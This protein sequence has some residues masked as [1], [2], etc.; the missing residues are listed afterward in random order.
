MKF[1]SNPVV[2]LVTIVILALLLLVPAGMIQNAIH[3]R[4][5]NQRTAT[6]SV[7]ETWGGTQSIVPA[8]LVLPYIKY[9]GRTNTEGNTSQ[10]K[11]SRKLYVMPELLEVDANVTPEV[12]DKGVFQVA[13]Y[14]SDLQVTGAFTLPNLDELGI[15]PEHVLWDEAELNVGISGLKSID[16]LVDIVWGDQNVAPEAG[17]TDS[18]V[19]SSGLHAVVAATP[20]KPIP[21]QVNL[22]LK[23][24]E[25]LRIAPVGK[26]TQVTMKGPWASPAYTG[27]FSPTHRSSEDGAFKAQWDIMHL[28]KNYPQYWKES[29][30]HNVNLELVETS[31]I[32]PVDR[33]TKNHRVTKYAILIIALTFLIFFFTESMKNKYV[34]PVQYTLV[35]LALV[36]FY[37]LLL[38]FSEHMGFN[39]AYAIAT[40]MTLGMEFLYAKSVLKSWT[41]AGYVAIVLGLLYSFIFILIQLEELA[42]LAGSVGL[43]I[44]LAAIMYISRNINWQELGKK[45]E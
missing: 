39:Q 28:N 33:Y 5:S 13:V 34:H 42:L 36:L 24:S 31:F 1:K 17:L 19:A 25:S 41:L 14:R 27:S 4:E 26:T 35:G 15:D 6:Y 43:F 40:L 30:E 38:S 3:E 8:Y 23:G 10:V 7:Q 37:T 16:G 11:Y 12:L 18:K 44:I 22:S 20:G 2:K 32:I 9:V 45:L 29:E 21:F